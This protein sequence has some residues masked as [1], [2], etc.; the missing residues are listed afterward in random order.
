MADNGGRIGP[1]DLFNFL[2]GEG[3]LTDRARSGL[4]DGATSRA[5]DE[6]IDRPGRNS[7]ARDELLDFEEDE[8]RRQR[9]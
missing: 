7:R 3:S 4:R 8:Q 1:R 9:L 5:V 2:F 6:Q